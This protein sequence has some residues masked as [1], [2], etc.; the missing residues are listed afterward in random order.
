MLPVPSAKRRLNPQWVENKVMTLV[1]NLTQEEDMMGHGKTLSLSQVNQLLSTF[2]DC[3]P[4]VWF[5]HH[6]TASTHPLIHGPCAAPAL[7]ILAANWTVASAPP[8]PEISSV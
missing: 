1:A 8:H 7:E 4:V 6:T 2:I 5:M 3:N